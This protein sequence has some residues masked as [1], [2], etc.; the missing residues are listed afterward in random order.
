MVKTRDIH[1]IENKN[2]IGV[3]VLGYE[4]KEKYQKNQENVVEKS[5]LIYY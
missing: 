4:N 1:K 5:M 2:S 3:S